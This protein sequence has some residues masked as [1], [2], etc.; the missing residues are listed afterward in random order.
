VKIE[1][2]DVLGN[3]ISSGFEGMLGAGN[4]AVPISLH[5]LAD[6]IYYTRIAGAQAQTLKLVKE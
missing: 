5:G 2:F 4:H 3:K 1:V 6:G